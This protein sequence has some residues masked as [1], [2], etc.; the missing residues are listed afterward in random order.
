MILTD[1]A[2][3]I[4]Y[5]IAKGI[6][7]TGREAEMFFDALEIAAA[8]RKAKA[9]GMRDAVEIYRSQEFQDGITAQDVLAAAD[10]IEKGEA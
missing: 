9:D 3:E 1:W 2:T 4:T 5:K 10:K 8:L 6:A 7:K